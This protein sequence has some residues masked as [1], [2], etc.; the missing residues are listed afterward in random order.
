ML[1]LLS[2]LSFLFFYNNRNNLE[3]LDFMLSLLSLL[4]KNW[5]SSF[6]FVKPDEQKQFP[7]ELCH[8]KKTKDVVKTI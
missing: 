1:S 2:L 6:V 8:G 7:I 5:I 4:F 3:Q